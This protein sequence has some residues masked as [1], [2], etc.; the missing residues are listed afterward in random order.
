MKKIL[1]YSAALILM[2]TGCILSSEKY[3]SPATYDLSAE[4]LTCS[5][6]VNG[7]RVRNSSGADR[8]FLYRVQNNRMQFDEYNFW[9]LPPEQLVRRIFDVSFSKRGRNAADIVCSI[10]RFEFDL[11]SNSAIL[12]LSVTVEKNGR[13]RHEFL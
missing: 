12:E 10:E 7:I 9:M 3:K 2:L 13:S 5:N 6:A 8:R 4:R 11:T 1:P